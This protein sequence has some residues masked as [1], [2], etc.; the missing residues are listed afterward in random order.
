[1]EAGETRGAPS[2]GGAD[3]ERAAAAFP[4][5]AAV[6][7]AAP[8]ESAGHHNPIDATARGA[9]AAS[10]SS[11]SASA[12]APPPKQTS[13]SSSA[14]NLATALDHSTTSSSPQQGCGRHPL[15][16]SDGAPTREESGDHHTATPSDVPSPPPDDP[17]G[18][19]TPQASSASQPPAELP[20]TRPADRAAGPSSRQSSRP[21]IVFD[22]DGNDAQ[23][24]RRVRRGSIRPPPAEP[25]MMTYL[26]RNSASGHSVTSRRSSQ[27]LGLDTSRR[28]YAAQ[29]PRRSAAQLALMRLTGAAQPAALFPADLKA[30]AIR[31]L[32]KGHWGRQGLH[33]WSY[34]LRERVVRKVW[35]DRLTLFL[36][37]LNCIFL[38]MEDP[39]EG[40]GHTHD[41]PEGH[42]THEGG[43]INE[44]VA[45]SEYVFTGLFAVE[46][47]IK[48]AAM[49]LYSH[50]FS[51]LRDPWCVL[52]GIIVV[53]GVVTIVISL[54]L[55]G[56]GGAGVG[57]LRAFRLLRPLR[58]VHHLTEV[59]VIVTSLLKSLP[60]LAD[61]L[62]LF[63]FFCLLMSVIAIQLFKGELRN[64][65]V[66]DGDLE[67]RVLELHYE[68]A[69]ADRPCAPLN[70]P[71]G[72]QCPW[73]YTC[74]V[75]GNPFWGYSSFDNIGYAVLTVFVAVTMEGWTDVMYNTQDGATGAAA[76][77]FVTLILIGSFFIANLALVM[78]SIAF[79]EAQESSRVEAEEREASQ[80]ATNAPV[81][82]AGVAVGDADAAADERILGDTQRRSRRSLIGTVAGPQPAA[83]P[84]P[85]RRLL[86]P[87]TYDIPAPQNPRP[88]PVLPTSQ[89]AEANG[90]APESP[91]RPAKS[92]AGRGRPKDDNGTLSPRGGK[93][94][95]S[96][97]QKKVSSMRLIGESPRQ[98]SSRMKLLKAVGI[99]V[100]EADENLGSPRRTTGSA[101][102]PETRE[103]GGNAAADFSGHDTETVGGSDC[104]TP[105][106]PEVGNGGFPPLP[107]PPDASNGVAGCV[108]ESETAA[109]GEK[110]AGSGGG[111]APC[112][113]AAELPAPPAHQLHTPVEE[114]E[115][116]GAPAAAV[117]PLGE[118]A[119]LEVQQ[120]NS[121]GSA[122]FS[123]R[124][125]VVPLELPR[126]ASLAHD[127]RELTL[128]EKCQAKVAEMVKTREFELFITVTIVLNTV[129]MAIE[130]PYTHPR[131][132]TE[133]LEYFNYV[134]TGIFAAESL[135]KIY[136][137][138]LKEFLADRM[139][140]FDAIIGI[141][142]IVDIIL[143]AMSGTRTGISVLRSLRLARIFK[144]FDGLWRTAKTI[145]RSLQGVSVLTGL[146]LLVIFVFALLGMQLFGGRF[147]NLEDPEDYIYSPD[148]FCPNLPRSNFD[149]LLLA[150]LSVFQI[151]TGEDWN[152]VMFH[153]M[154]G[155]GAFA[156]LYF[157][158]VFVIG[159]IIMLNLFIAVLIN[160]FDTGDDG[161]DDMEY[162]ADG[163]AILDDDDEDEHQSLARVNESL[164]QL[165]GEWVRQSLDR[166]SAPPP[167]HASEAHPDP[168]SSNGAAENG[169]RNGRVKPR[170]V[171]ADDDS[172]PGK[173][174]D[175]TPKKRG[176][177]GK[178]FACC[179]PPP[180]GKAE[181]R[182]G[183]P[184]G[185]PRGLNRRLGS[186][187]PSDDGRP[188]IS[189]R[190]KS[191]LSMGGRE[192]ASEFTGA[193]A[194]AAPIKNMI[195]KLNV[196]ATLGDTPARLGAVNDA[197]RMV[198]LSSSVFTATAVLPI[199]GRA[200][201]DTNEGGFAAMDALAAGELRDELIGAFVTR[202]GAEGA[203]NL[204]IETLLSLLEMLDL[205]TSE[206]CKQYQQAVC[207]LVESLQLQDPVLHLTFARYGW[208]GIAFTIHLNPT[209]ARDLHDELE[210]HNRISTQEHCRPGAAGAGVPVNVS[211]MFPSQLALAE[212]NIKLGAA[213]I[214]ETSDGED[215]AGRRHLE[216]HRP[217]PVHEAFAKLCACGAM[218]EDDSL[219]FWLLSTQNP[220]R[221][222]FFLVVTHPA[223]EAIVIGLI[224]LSSIS[225]AL[226]DPSAAPD[227]P[228]PRTN[229]VI[230]LVLVVC[231]T[232]ECVMKIIAHGF[233]LHPSSYL[234][235][236]GWNVL[237]FVIVLFS[238]VALTLSGSTSVGRVADFF[239]SMRTLRPLRFI[240]KSVGL[241][242]VATALISS[243][244]PLAD[245][246]FVTV[247]IFLI[248]GIMGV[249]FFAGMFYACTLEEWGDISYANAT[250]G[251]APLTKAH[252]L[253][254]LD[255]EG[256]P[257]YRWENNINNFDHVGIALLT[258]FE[259]ATLE[260]WVGVMHL[261]MD[262]VGPDKAPVKMNQ[263][264][265]SLYF[266]LFI[267]IGSF[268]VINLFVGVLIDQY[269]AAR[270]RNQLEK[271]VG[272][273]QSQINWV[274]VQEVILDN[275]PKM[276]K[277]DMSEWR[278]H[279]FQVVQHQYFHSFIT[280]AVAVNVLVMAVEH[281]DEGDDVRVFQE[282]MNNIFVCTFLLEAL[283]KLTAHGPRGYFRD[284]W[285]RFDLSLVVL[286]I[287]GMIF[288]YT[289]GAN[290]LVRSILRPMRLA[291]LIRVVRAA[292][293]V[294]AL[295]KTLLLS[296]GNLVN[297]AGLLS[298][299]FF[300]YAVLG[301]ELFGRVGRGDCLHDRA[302]F[303]RF[304]NAILLLFRMSTGEAWQC[305]MHDCMR[306]ADDHGQC[307]PQLNACGSSYQAVLYFTTFMFLGMY[308]LLNVFI[309]I[310]LS[311]Y[312]CVAM[313]EN[314]LLT[315]EHIWEFY[316]QWERRDPC[317]TRLI[318]ISH[319]PSHIRSLPPPLGGDGDADPITR[320]LLKKTMLTYIGRTC[321]SYDN[322]VSYQELLMALVD[323]NCFKY[324]VVVS[325]PREWA[326]LLAKYEKKW[327]ALH[328][329]GYSKELEELADGHANVALAA[330]HI[331]RVWR[332]KKA[333]Q[334]A[335]ERLG[336][337]VATEVPPNAA[338]PVQT[339]DLDPPA[340]ADLSPPEDAL[341]PD[342]APSDSANA[343]LPGC[344]PARQPSL[345]ASAS[346]SHQDS[347]ED[348]HDPPD[349]IPGLPALTPPQSEA[350][351]PPAESTASAA[352]PVADCT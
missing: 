148:D 181:K 254:F 130:A 212:G 294:R 75:D 149:T 176:G 82:N 292:A 64:R 65:C 270:D 314:A 307:D 272:L 219:A 222:A 3:A 140:I 286:S 110:P 281:V 59:R 30:A 190:R 229:A 290:S 320:A 88:K 114:K 333:R 329:S 143:F 159:N 69:D 179:T 43:T 168:S 136:G 338:T 183:S 4:L 15:K 172:G 41:G 5:P 63:G 317:G 308:I 312:E 155:K 104:G 46:M 289:P 257:L 89:P 95:A 117:P 301:V 235:R 139:N 328:T 234:R 224:V 124:A 152:I 83:P 274:E 22:T 133:A 279:L 57:G 154:R 2:P 321:R 299:L 241:K 351:D 304:P 194:V 81:A 288:T 192:S 209:T 52:D 232:T 240:N 96:M 156:S 202:A 108:A 86:T 167:Q 137:F 50:P 173:D 258:L 191:L 214:R 76:I 100:N 187:P 141:L 11:D 349:L 276:N 264:W 291:R 175:D 223:F 144:R 166:H 335:M 220:V 85:A 157:V 303:D 322:Q 87:D 97:L 45:I 128:N 302:N 348:S 334:R 121:V 132:L 91:R 207:K 261:G 12:K 93:A 153:G 19:G 36:I 9:A 31:E 250:N 231:F 313:E 171:E 255:D 44:V 13:S 174:D 345:A 310:I 260:G 211:A 39:T 111:E 295:L 112:A 62:L 6:P 58:A 327:A 216:E 29:Q 225:L 24:E 197:V 203:F 296:L 60:R 74:E 266:I 7:A 27:F 54:T 217:H 180:K 35:F 263:P 37:M 79:F 300:L 53:I 164:M 47:A 101:A 20:H 247:L 298:L 165:R 120:C 23:P 17:F 248:F 245:I 21:G 233:A 309:A 56:G 84:P 188:G 8:A 340:R 316:A 42:H 160:N 228:L 205:L 196:L 118:S 262:A 195:A 10:T 230:D 280:V 26:R 218:E 278:K 306:E 246:T 347:H 14:N 204:D 77:Y 163:T 99:K 169:A 186:I 287:I 98:L 265:M 227:E 71:G 170:R 1:M 352:E 332:G 34:E 189:P 92:P 72:F 331:Q 162:D 319:V 146:L 105:L 150:L 200:G 238:I 244:R 161:G 226:A 119:L 346:G 94:G 48:I 49:G 239:R 78:I 242:M 267:V 28:G 315:E 208:T 213:L 324:G 158:A 252:C 55:D 285:N 275:T 18:V 341:H 342:P 253:S 127:D 251:T 268:F 177:V 73:G 40:T 61:V 199:I 131:K 184:A 16:N 151:I 178:L 135:L 198:F 243:L 193:H 129:A 123:P 330:M 113:S 284:P 318:P 236:D 126:V 80:A 142:S 326:G 273:T 339:F 269:N 107:P 305:I 38:A 215:S 282:V 106:S 283:L 109:G 145:M 311:G 182:G 325:D 103:P 343:P 350:L 102:P 90:S 337:S 206:N 277:Q 115:G 25:H 122:D 256:A 293:G 70:R 259:V 138:P 125:L 134:F 221:R 67:A 336:L 116:G 344:V 210:T 201:W 297:V 249:Q 68:S 237:D 323:F 66:L 51:Y 185:T 147:C 33:P 32:D 271:Y